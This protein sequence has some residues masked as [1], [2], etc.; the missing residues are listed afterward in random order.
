M[1]GLENQFNRMRSK[2]PRA[3]CWD[4]VAWLNKE[5]LFCESKRS[6]HDSIRDSQLA[7][8]EAAL[9]EGMGVSQFLIVEWSYA[10]GKAQSADR[11]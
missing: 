5:I 4:I 6:G 8:L 3:R 7:W 11:I 10:G 1:D 2:A 9:N